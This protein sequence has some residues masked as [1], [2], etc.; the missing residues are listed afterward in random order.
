MN[1]VPHAYMEHA[2][3]ASVFAVLIG[4]V[5]VAVLVCKESERRRERKGEG[6]GERE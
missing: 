5:Q 2:T 3:K 6:E 4:L 1:V